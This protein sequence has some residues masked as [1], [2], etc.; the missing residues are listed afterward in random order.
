MHLTHEHLFHLRELL[1]DRCVPGDMAILLRTLRDALCLEML[2]LAHLNSIQHVVLN[3]LGEPVKDSTSAQRI[4]LPKLT[5]LD[6]SHSSDVHDGPLICIVVIAHTTQ[7]T[8]FGG[9][10]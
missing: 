10:A 1:I 5:R 9:T 6:I 8:R 3:T 7:T 4:L 2:D